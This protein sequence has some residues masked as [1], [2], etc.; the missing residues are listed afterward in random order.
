MDG[1]SMV[2]KA[3]QRT[4]CTVVLCVMAMSGCRSLP[5]S[6]ETTSNTT[7][8]LG[9]A[10]L[11]ALV[12]GYESPLSQHWNEWGSKNLQDGDLVFTMGESRVV[13]GL[14]DFSAFSSDIAASRFSHVGIV[15][16]EDGQ[17]YVYDTVSGGPRRKEL[18]WYLARGKVRRVAIKRPHHHVAHHGP[19]AVNFCRWVHEEQI[20]FDEQFKLDDD[21][22]Y[23]A[24]LVDLAYRRSGLPLCSPVAIHSLPNFDE[25]SPSTVWLVE[26]FTSISPDQT[27]ILPGNETHGIWSS[28]AF[29]VLLHEQSPINGPPKIM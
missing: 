12:P 29:H 10:L 22:Y 23:C 14:I 4:F 26:T 25:F 16:I 6:R 18:G 7:P 8:H 1:L 3:T 28:S 17:P 15:A 13:M 5:N 2:E 20:P 11:D 9:T 21:R 27:V 19:L 24:E